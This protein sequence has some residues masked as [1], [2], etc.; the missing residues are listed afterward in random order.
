MTQDIKIYLRWVKDLRLASK[1][2][3]RNR[4]GNSY[5]LQ[6]DKDFLGHKKQEQKKKKNNELDFIKI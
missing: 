3:A 4:G 2:S 1:T 6:V 5:S